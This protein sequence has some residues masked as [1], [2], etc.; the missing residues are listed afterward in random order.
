MITCCPPFINLCIF[1]ILHSNLLRNTLA[2]ISTYSAQS[3]LTWIKG[4]D[5]WNTCISNQLPKYNYSWK[6]KENLLNHH[7]LILLSVI[8]SLSIM[9]HCTDICVILLFYVYTM[10]WPG[11]ELR[12]LSLQVRS[13]TYWAMLALEPTF[14]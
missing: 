14:I 3:I 4:I 9:A 1:N 10:P 13:F 2:K 11:I 6:V 8:F 5:Q 7:D 12:S